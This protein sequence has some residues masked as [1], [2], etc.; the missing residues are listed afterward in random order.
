MLQC[1]S[2]ESTE[3]I[4][5]KDKLTLCEIGLSSQIYNISFQFIPGLGEGPGGV[6]CQLCPLLFIKSPRKF[7]L[8]KIKAH[9]LLES[10]DNPELC[11]YSHKP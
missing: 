4:C 7:F 8:L 2:R 10:T 11:G 3:L 5:Q 6:S 1:C 9:F